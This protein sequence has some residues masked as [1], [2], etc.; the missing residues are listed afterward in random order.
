MSLTPDLCCSSIAKLRVVGFVRPHMVYA[1]LPPQ[2]EQC[3]VGG[4]RV[5][6][7]DAMAPP[8]GWL[9]AAHRH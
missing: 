7:L 4:E 3:V 2:L 6:R 9:R 1:W 8:L 5:E